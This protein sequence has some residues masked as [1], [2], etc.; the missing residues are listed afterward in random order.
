MVKRGRVGVVI[1]VMDH[2]VYEDIQNVKIYWTDGETVW[3]LDTRTL[4]KL[5]AEYD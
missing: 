2:A 4:K 5:E 1:V 3:W